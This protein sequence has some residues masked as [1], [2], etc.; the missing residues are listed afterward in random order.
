MAVHVVDLLEA[1]KVHHEQRDLGLQALGTGQLAR[2]VH[3]HEPRVRQAGQR[4]GE[5]VAL[6]LLEDDRIVDDAGRLF[7]YAIQQAPM[8]VGESARL[9]IV[10]RQRADEPIV[11]HQRTDQR[12]LQ[13]SSR[14]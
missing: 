2:E 6:G 7:R 9:G 11:E 13:R 12:R 4:I 8:V 14:R 5:G 3:E 10:H 1:V